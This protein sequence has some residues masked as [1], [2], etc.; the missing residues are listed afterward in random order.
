MPAPRIG[1]HAS[2]NLHRS[3]RPRELRPEGSPGSLLNFRVHLRPNSY[4]KGSRHHATPMR[5]MRRF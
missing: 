1:L 4:R 5:R 2:R 3:L